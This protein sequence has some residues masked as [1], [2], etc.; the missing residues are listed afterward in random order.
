MNKEDNSQHHHGHMN[1]F[2]LGVIVGA[3]L[4]FLLATKKGKKILKLIS[5]EG[6]ESLTDL[7]KDEDVEEVYAEDQ[8]PEEPIIQPDVEV[9]QEQDAV[10][11]KPK[12]KRFFK[13]KK[14]S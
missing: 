6:I 3:A 8:V 5:E 4:V 14:T 12:K 10:S 9:K 2:L 1:G 13:R 7:L 11:P